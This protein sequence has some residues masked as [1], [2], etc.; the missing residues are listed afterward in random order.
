MSENYT[1][2]TMFL[3]RLTV[4]DELY[5]AFRNDETRSVVI[6]AS[7][8]SPADQQAFEQGDS[9][10]I[11]RR[12]REEEVVKEEKVNPDVQGGGIR[13]EVPDHEDDDD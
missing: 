2:V 11:L 5:E 1:S 6:A 3:M 9:E 7:G 8:M 13:V 10:E 4:D 12:A